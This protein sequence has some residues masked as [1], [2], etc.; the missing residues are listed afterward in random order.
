MQAVFCVLELAEDESLAAETVAELCDVAVK[1]VKVKC[2]ADCTRGYERSFGKLAD[3]YLWTCKYWYGLYAE[4]LTFVEIRNLSEFGVFFLLQ[5]AAQIRFRISV[6]KLSFFDKTG[7]EILNE[8]S[9]RSHKHFDE[10]RLTAIRPYIPQLER[11]F[12][13]LHLS[14]NPFS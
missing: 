7:L 12:K 13:V 11:Y 6:E 9:S 3:I 14:H 5:Y 8:A 4:K 1:D 2:L 10:K